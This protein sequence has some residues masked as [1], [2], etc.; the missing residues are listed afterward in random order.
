MNYWPSSQIMHE[1]KE[2]QYRREL[3]S[4]GT[5]RVF[6]SA[7]V[8]DACHEAACKLEPCTSLVLVCSEAAPIRRVY[9][10]HPTQKDWIALERSGFVTAFDLFG[11]VMDALH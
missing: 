4:I 10:H 5:E 8:L 3:M 11:F 9:L 7:Y 6:M 2:P 1:L